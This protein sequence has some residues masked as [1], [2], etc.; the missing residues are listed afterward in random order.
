[1][2]KRDET[3]KTLYV[4][5]PRE[6]KIVKVTQSN[7]VNEADFRFTKDKISPP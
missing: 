2:K 6:L 4:I 7:E 3:V 5:S 1:M